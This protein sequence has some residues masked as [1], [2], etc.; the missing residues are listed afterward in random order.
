METNEQIVAAG[1][2]VIHNYYSLHERLDKA[3]EELGELQEKLVVLRKQDENLKDQAIAAYEL[4]LHQEIADVVI[5][6]TQLAMTY[7]EKEV[8]TKIAQKIA[9]QLQ[10]INKEIAEKL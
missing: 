6:T 4:D 3:I 7:G 1:I 2:S 9:R 5:V 10:R 8:T